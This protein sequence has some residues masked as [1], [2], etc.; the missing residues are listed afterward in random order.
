MNQLTDDKNDNTKVLGTT[1]Q[2]VT[3]AQVTLQ[4]YE[5]HKMGANRSARLDCCIKKVNKHVNNQLTSLSVDQNYVQ[6]LASYC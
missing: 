6:G 2:Y 5:T 1:M 4:K 3:C